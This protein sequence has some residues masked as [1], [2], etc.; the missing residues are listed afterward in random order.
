MLIGNEFTY[1]GT[2]F[3]VSRNLFT[4]LIRCFE[5]VFVPCKLRGKYSVS[6]QF[7]FNLQPSFLERPS[8]PELRA[9]FFKAENAKDTVEECRI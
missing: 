3:C 9:T 7:V 1:V 6:C 4:N 5:P 2:A 8:D